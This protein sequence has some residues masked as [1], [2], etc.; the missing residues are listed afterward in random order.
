MLGVSVMCLRILGTAVFSDPVTVSV[1][2][3]FH[4][5][6]VPLFILAI[7]RYFT[8]HFN[9]ALS[10]TL[11]MVGFQISA[12]IGNVVL[13]QPLGALRDAI[14]YQPTFFVISA[15]VAC[16]GVYAWFTVKRDDEDVFGDPV[17]TEPT[18]KA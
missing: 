17:P 5:V 7:F 10:A 16:A 15:V 4:A 9:A 2:K 11:Y 13:S 18:V 14:G 3:M 12:Q 1:V 8:L 6:E